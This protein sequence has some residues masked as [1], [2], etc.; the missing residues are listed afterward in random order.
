M[1]SSDWESVTLKCSQGYARP[2]RIH[3]SGKA[4]LLSHEDQATGTP[5]RV[6]H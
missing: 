4:V 5:Y 6:P 3:G 1:I 2:S